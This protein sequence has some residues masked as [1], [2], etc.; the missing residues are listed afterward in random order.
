MLASVMRIVLQ[1]YSLNQIGQRV[2]WVYR[3]RALELAT[4]FSRVV[5]MVAPG[6]G[7]VLEVELGASGT[8]ITLPPPWPASTDHL[9]NDQL[10]PKLHYSYAPLVMGAIYLGSQTRA[11]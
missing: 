2:W 9:H 4:Q 1:Q 7:L 3:K 5:A 10:T 11:E 8:S 6:S